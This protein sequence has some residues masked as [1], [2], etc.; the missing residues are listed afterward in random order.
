MTTITSPK[1]LR[2]KKELDNIPD[3]PGYYKWWAPGP[4][5]KKLLG[6]FY[7]ELAP[8]LTEGKGELSGYFYIYVGIA[9]KSLRDRLNWHINQINSVGAVKS[10]FLSTLRKSISSLALGDQFDTDGTN[11]IINRM[12]AQYEVCGDF[13]EKE[14]KEIDGHMLPLNIKGQKNQKLKNGFTKYLKEVRRAGK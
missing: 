5:V 3:S 14:D 8:G 13:K 11:D 12:I 1:V 7:H 6:K 10:G 9:S 4:T 2:D